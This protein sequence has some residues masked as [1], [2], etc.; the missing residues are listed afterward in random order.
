MKNE[1][2]EMAW[3]LDPLI[4]ELG[5]AKFMEEGKKLYDQIVLGQ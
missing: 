5:E 1:L 4:K 3:V 2:S